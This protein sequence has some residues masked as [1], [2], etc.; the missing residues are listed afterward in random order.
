M[1]M[2]SNKWALS[3]RFFHWASALLLVITWALVEYRDNL[4]GAMD[5]HKSFGV[6]VLF[7]IVA[8]IIN[9][10]LVKRPVLYRKITWQIM[11]ARITHLALYACLLAM[12]LAGILMSMYGGR[13]INV[14]G[15]V[16]I[17]PMMQPNRTNASFFNNL[18]TNIIWTVLVLLTALHI[19]GALYHQFIKKDRLVQTML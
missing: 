1:G 17:A 7:F 16:Q 15:I 14:F 2:L 11:L 4:D 12:P 13:A 6:T 9:R 10:F 19:G 18:H 3:A 8:R 5:L